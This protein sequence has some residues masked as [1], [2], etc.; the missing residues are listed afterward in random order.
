MQ[1][2]T[3]NMKILSCLRP[4]LRPLGVSLLCASAVIT[5]RAQ[6]ATAPGDTIYNPEII[7]SPMPRTYEIAG[8]DVSGISHVEDY[9]IIGYSGLSVG[10]RI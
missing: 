10:E 7:Y 5:G 6:T 8:I 2:P 3:C 1:L 4:H 9:V